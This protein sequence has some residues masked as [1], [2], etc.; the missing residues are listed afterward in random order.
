MSLY[1]NMLGHDFWWYSETIG[2]WRFVI[3]SHKCLVSENRWFPKKNDA[4]WP[5]SYVS[6]D[7]QPRPENRPRTGWQS[8]GS[9]LI[10][11]PI[12]GAMNLLT[13]TWIFTWHLSPGYV[14]F[15]SINSH[16]P[17][18]FEMIRSILG[19]N[20][21]EREREG[22]NPLVFLLH[23]KH[24]WVSS[25]D[26]Q[27]LKPICRI[28]HHD[29]ISKISLKGKRIPCK[30]LSGWCH[31]SKVHKVKAPLWWTNQPRFFGQ[32]FWRSSWFCP[33]HLFFIYFLKLSI[34]SL[35]V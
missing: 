24:F 2:N 17:P 23:F 13:W 31:Q 34:L 4:I 5:P 12:L 16:V 14:R 25:Q 33:D 29:L 9:P 22:N 11:G 1:A 28:S 27:T 6:L 8:L 10:L 26:S 15:S 21:N 20:T 7:A 18:K 30:M 19:I 32:I 35:S 3:G